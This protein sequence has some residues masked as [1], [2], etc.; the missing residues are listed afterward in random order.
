[1][2]DL[3]PRSQQDTSSWGLEQAGPNI[4]RLSQVQ[5]EAPTQS[6]PPFSSHLNTVHSVCVCVCVVAW[7]HICVQTTSFECPALSNPHPHRR[8]PWPPCRG[9]SAYSSS[10]ENWPQAHVGPGNGTWFRKVVC[11]RWHVSLQLHRALT[12]Q[13][14]QWPERDP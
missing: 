11:S 8:H 9:G 5:R 13:G 6:P 3:Q 2:F 12:L 14:G 10:W 1:M 7:V 4:C